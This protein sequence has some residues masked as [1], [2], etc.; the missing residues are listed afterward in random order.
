MKFQ[1]CFRFSH[2]DPIVE[3][4]DLL[5]IQLRNTF[6]AKPIYFPM[7]IFTHAN[8]AVT[9]REATGRRKKEDPFNF[10]KLASLQ[11]PGKNVYVSV[12]NVSWMTF[13]EQNVWQRVEYKEE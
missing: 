8:R 3:I 1:M 9:Q 12:L 4:W 5:E 7:G 11:R 13:G 6:S 2:W 10:N